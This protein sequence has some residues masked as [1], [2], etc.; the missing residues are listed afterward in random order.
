ME[1]RRKAV[2]LGASELRKLLDI[3]HKVRPGGKCVP[4]HRLAIIL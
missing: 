4:R 3:E 2:T 1:V